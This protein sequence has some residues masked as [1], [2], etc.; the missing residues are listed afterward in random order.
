M[1]LSLKYVRLVF[2][3]PY[4]KLNLERCEISVYKRCEISVHKAILT[5][6]V[7]LVN[8]L[9]KRGCVNESCEIVHEAISS[10]L[11]AMMIGLQPLSISGVIKKNSSKQHIPC[12]TA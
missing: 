7:R 6:H 9:M 8:I 5:N 11:L 4:N 3:P 10:V 1:R 2:H 12:I